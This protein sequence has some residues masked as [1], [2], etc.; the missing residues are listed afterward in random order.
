MTADITIAIT[1]GIITI[2]IETAIRAIIPFTA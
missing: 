2:Q 1:R